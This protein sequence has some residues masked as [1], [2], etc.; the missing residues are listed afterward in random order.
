MIAANPQ[1]PR[2]WAT[3]R[4]RR[5]GARVGTSTGHARLRGDAR[6]FMLRERGET[7]MNRC[8]SVPKLSPPSRRR[9]RAPD[10]GLSVLVTYPPFRRSPTNRSTNAR[11]FPRGVLIPHSQS[12]SVSGSTPSCLASTRNERPCRRRAHWMR[13]ASSLG[14]GSGF[15]SYPRNSMI[16]GQKRS[17]GFVKSFSQFARVKELTP[18]RS[19]AS[20]C[21]RLRSCL[22]LRRWSPRVAGTL[23]YGVGF[24]NPRVFG[25]TDKKAT[26]P[27]KL[28]GRRSWNSSRLPATWRQECLDRCEPF[29]GGK[30]HTSLPIA[31]RPSVHAQLLCQACLR[32]S[33]QLSH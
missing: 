30:P 21:R 20:F 5:R 17:L 22:R 2:R 3:P 33:Q 24:R 32:Q 31:D 27:W 9:R 23:G 25:L 4:S 6:A 15:G 8:R 1:R 26:N 11:Y 29:L 13:C 18:R 12:R 14:F 28:A 19:A 10:T 16:F 7:N